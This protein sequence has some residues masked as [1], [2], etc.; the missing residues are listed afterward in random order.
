VLREYGRKHGWLDEHARFTKI[1]NT[2][3]SRGVYGPDLRNTL[4]ELRDYRNKIHVYLNAHVEMHN[5]VPVR[6]D[7]A[8]RT[9]HEV[10]AA[11]MKHWRES[12]EELPF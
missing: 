11:V 3:Q 2:M 10:E 4:H 6:F 5:G 12:L 7:N 1:I 8:E 9:L